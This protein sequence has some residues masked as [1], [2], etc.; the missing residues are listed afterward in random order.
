MSL[1][2]TIFLICYR[3]HTDLVFI[4]MPMNSSGFSINQTVLGNIQIFRL[5]RH[6]AGDIFF[7]LQLHKDFPDIC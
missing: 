4:F 5:R 6:A 1:K 3:K 7:L 2:I